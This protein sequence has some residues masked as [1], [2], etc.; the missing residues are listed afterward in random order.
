[1]RANQR[2]PLAIYTILTCSIIFYCL[3]Y[4]FRISPS[5]V[6]VALMQQYHTTPFGIGAM[7]SAFYVGYVIMQIPAGI[8]LDRYDFITIFCLSILACTMFFSLFTFSQQAWLALLWRFFIGAFSAFSFIGVLYFAKCYLHE[9]YFTTIAAITIALGTLTAAS[10]QMITAYIMHYIPWHFIYGAIAL[11]CLLLVIVLLISSRLL[12]HRAQEKSLIKLEFIRIYQQLIQLFNLN[13][14]LFS[15]WNPL[16]YLRQGVVLNG[17][18]GSL[19]YLPTSIFAGL[20]GISF[21]QQTYHLTRRQSSWGILL[22]FLGWAIGSPFIG[23]IADRIHWY[24]RLIFFFS[25]FAA[26]NAIIL[27][28]FPSHI[29]H[30]V[31][32]SLFLFG[33]FSSAQVVVWKI[34]NELVPKNIAGTGVAVTNMIITLSA[35]IFHLIV[36]A[37]LSESSPATMNFT[38]ALSIIPL[39]F[40]LSALISLLIKIPKRGNHH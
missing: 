5:L 29:N 8:L 21:L 13:K 3:D 35:A 33:I 14:T 20:W 16:R 6:V 4:F 1:M 36:G 15:R 39:A 30:N 19:Y 11:F 22:L 25:L 27:I 40:L 34:F 24:R 26:A 38:H 32:F 37:L 7:G 18:V 28:Y 12:L 10:M 17:I 9:R 2:Y 31:F 23:W